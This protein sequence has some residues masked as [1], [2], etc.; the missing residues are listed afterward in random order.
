MGVFSRVATATRTAVGN[1]GVRALTYSVAKG[2]ALPGSDGGNV[3]YGGWLGGSGGH[4]VPHEPFTGAWQRNMDNAAAAGPSLLANSAIYTC[5]TIISSDIAVLPVRLL[6]VDEDSDIRIPHVRHP[7]WALMQRPNSFQTSLQ[8][9]QQYLVSKLTY[10]NTYVLLVR[11]ARYVVTEMFVLD[12][13]SVQVLISDDGSVFYRLGRDLLAGTEQAIVV[14]ARDII[15]DRMASIGHQM[16]GGALIGTSPLYAAA[17]PAMMQGRMLMA[18]ETFF[19][20]MS[21]ASGVLVAPGKIDPTTARKL[22]AEWESNYSG[23]GLGKTAVLTNGLEFKPMSVNATD[24]QLPAQLGWTTRNIASIYRVP[25]YMLGEMD[26]ATYRNSEQM[27]RDYYRQCLSYYIHSF[28]QCFNA[29]LNLPNGIVV[30]FDLAELFRMELDSRYN[31][32]QVG[33]N[34]GF[35]AINE[36]RALEDLPPVAGGDIPRVQMQSVPLELADALAQ[37][38][39]TNELAPPPAPNPSPAPAPADDTKI[40]QLEFEFE[41]AQMD[42]LV[43]AFGENFTLE[44]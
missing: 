27:S 20:N 23:K 3:G 37:A 19:A 9:I 36:V 5:T 30:E 34:A 41:P 8:F 22:Q 2:Y 43:A 13:A 11:D 24:S 40:E 33:L 4:G 18:S 21:R 39:V 42:M 15:H 44:G 17:L 32:Y 6:R 1:L 10:G 31:A 12:P 26:K 7:Y 25:Q 28:E 35:L 38:Q 16:Y 14:P 29:G